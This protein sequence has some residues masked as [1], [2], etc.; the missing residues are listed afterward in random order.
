MALKTLDQLFEADARLMKN[1]TLPPEAYRATVAGAVEI[2]RESSARAAFPVDIT[3]LGPGALKSRK[4]KLVDVGEAEHGMKGTGGSFDRA[5]YEM[6]DQPFY[7]V[8]KNIEVPM[9]EQKASEMGGLNLNLF[10]DSGNAAGEVVVET[11]NKLLFVG[12]G[13]IKG[14]TQATGIQTMGGASWAT[15]GN[16]YKDMIKARGKL[17]EKKVPLSQLAIAMN[18]VDAVNFEQTFT[19]TAIPQQELLNRQFPGGIHVYTDIPAGEAYVYQKSRPVLEARIAQDV[20]VIPL[21]ATDEDDRMRVRTIPTL[22]VTRPTGIV[23][24][25]GIT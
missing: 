18:P 19:S 7:P 4:I 25:T 12:L 3:N 1:A 15:G 22:H 13:P 8:W 11:E 16:A 5:N 20:T 23:K 6:D 17:R 10:R 24:I 14:L 21:P 9:R 2:F